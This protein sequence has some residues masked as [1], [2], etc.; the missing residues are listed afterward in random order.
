MQNFTFF[1]ISNIYNKIG[2]IM[3]YLFVIKDSYFKENS[4]FLYKLLY[5]I[6]YMK[7]ENYNYGISLYYNICNLFKVKVL[8]NYIKNKFNLKTKNNIFYLDNENYFELKNVCCI[9]NANKYLRQIFMIFYIYNKNI[10]VCNF[11]KDE[12]FWLKDKFN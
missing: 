3:Y 2:D 9:I 8:K 11:S 7:K 1:L 6:K 5:E 4:D 12:Y 10:F